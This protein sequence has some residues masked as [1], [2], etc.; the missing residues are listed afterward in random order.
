MKDTECLTYTSYKCKYHIVIV[1]KYRRMVIYNKLKKDID[2]IIRIL[3]NTN[4]AT[5]DEED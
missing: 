1:P 2:Q 4:F 5:I 3:I